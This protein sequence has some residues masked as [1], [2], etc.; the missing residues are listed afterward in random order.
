MTAATDR[1][2]PP[3][4]IAGLEARG[5]D[6]VRNLLGPATAPA[7]G[8]QVPGLEA[9]DGKWIIRADAELWLQQKRAA[10]AAALAQKEAAAA[11][12]ETIRS[13]ALS[14]ISAVAA[15]VAAWE[16]WRG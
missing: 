4:V 16:G 7:A 2:L 6:A 3:E 12:R 10:K 9:S 14:A 5:P 8:S 13:V 1:K 15:I 11:R